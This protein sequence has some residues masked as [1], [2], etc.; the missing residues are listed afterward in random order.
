MMKITPST[1]LEIL[2]RVFPGFLS[3]FVSE[4]KLTERLQELQDLLDT[5]PSRNSTVE[6]FCFVANLNTSDFTKCLNRGF[7]SWLECEISVQELSRLSNN[8]SPHTGPSERIL[9]I[10]VRE[11]W[12]R[13]IASLPHAVPFSQKNASNLM[14][15]AASAQHVI[16]FCHHGIR[17]LYAA[18]YFRENGISNAKSLKG[19]IDAFSKQ[20]DSS[21]PRY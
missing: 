17:S 9:L 2:A 5:L 12:E 8:A 11:D 4:F 16:I 20:I 21:I 13:D 1:S 7:A 15:H 10:D 14:K 6:N 19:G 3:F 18:T